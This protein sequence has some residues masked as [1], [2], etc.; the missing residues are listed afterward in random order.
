MRCAALPHVGQ[1]TRTRW[2]DTG[3]EIAPG[4]RDQHVYLS[5][6]A[7]AEAARLF[8]WVPGGELIAAKRTL[9][10]LEAE[11]ATARAEVA[12]LQRAWDAI[13]RVERLGFEAKPA[14][15]KPGPKAKVS[16]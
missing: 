2:V 14:P 8:G 3:A 9:T 7:V 5:E 1:M 12:E 11:L 10:G 13:D 16:A 4:G 15:S 6:V